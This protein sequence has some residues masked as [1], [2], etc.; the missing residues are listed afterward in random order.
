MSAVLILVTK[1]LNIKKN[2]L[3][4]LILEQFNWNSVGFLKKHL[5]IQDIFVDVVIVI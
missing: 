3:I 2:I 1:V 4:Q 5:Y